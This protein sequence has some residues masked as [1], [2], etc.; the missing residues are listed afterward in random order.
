VRVLT[1][2]S[3][4][5]KV[6]SPISQAASASAS[7]CY[8]KTVA[9]AGH[10]ALVEAVKVKSNKIVDLL[11]QYNALPNIKEPSTGITPLHVAFEEGLPEVTAYWKP[12]SLPLP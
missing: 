6:R 2:I 1:L 7:I 10:A 12:S 11:L 8:A 3:L 5:A 4:G 9:T